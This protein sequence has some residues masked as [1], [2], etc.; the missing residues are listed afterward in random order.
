MDRPVTVKLISKTLVQNEQAA[1][2]FRREARPAAVGLVSR[3]S[4]VQTAVRNYTRDE[5]GP[6]GFGDRE[7]IPSHR[8]L[9][10]SKALVVSVAEKSGR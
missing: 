4:P 8:K 10:W 3:A 1:E 9:L 2:R 7:L 6:F 5:G